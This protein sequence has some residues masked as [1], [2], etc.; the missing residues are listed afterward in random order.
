MVDA[1]IEAAYTYQSWGAEKPNFFLWRL[2]GAGNTPGLGV[3]EIARR[4]AV[5]GEFGDAFCEARYNLAVVPLPP[6]V[7]GRRPPGAGR[8]ALPRGG[9]YFD[10]RAALPGHGRQIVVR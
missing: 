2:P 7:G 8:V 10:R 5:A 9:R 1:Q 4:L 3:G 6:G